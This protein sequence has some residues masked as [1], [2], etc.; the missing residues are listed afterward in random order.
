VVTSLPAHQFEK[1]YLY[2]EL[3][4]ARGDRASTHTFRGNAIRLWFSMAAHLLIVTVRQVGFV[5]TELASA[6]AEKLR[7]KI[8]KIGALANVSVRRIHL[9]LSSGFPRKRLLVLALERLA[10]P[11]G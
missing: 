5:G 4:C 1:R 11:S 9:R 2:E 3:Y 10:R 8:L 6:Q 7:N